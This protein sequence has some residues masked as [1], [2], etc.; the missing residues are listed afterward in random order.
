MKANFFT[1]VPMYGDFKQAY[2]SQLQN[3]FAFFKEVD[4][5]VAKAF[6]EMENIN[7]ASSQNLEFVFINEL[8]PIINNKTDGVATVEILYDGNDIRCFIKVDGAMLIYPSDVNIQ[9]IFHRTFVANG[10][11]C[12][13]P[14]T[15]DLKFLDETRNIIVVNKDGQQHYVDR[16]L[17]PDIRLALNTSTNF[18]FF[19][20]YPPKHMTKTKAEAIAWKIFFANN[21]KFTFLAGAWNKYGTAVVVEN[22]SE[23]KYHLYFANPN[24]EQ[25]MLVG[26][27]MDQENYRIK[28]LNNQFLRAVSHDFEVSFERVMIS[29]LGKPA[30]KYYINGAAATTLA[31]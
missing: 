31:S 4:K 7:I 19:R 23:W 22:K 12:R 20:T 15:I 25:A 16:I 5:D 2:L 14:K 30:Y 28:F 17:D 3:S 21:K 8:E 11:F 6:C 18:L 10:V 24:K 27:E 9:N 1:D 29:C 26:E 13:N